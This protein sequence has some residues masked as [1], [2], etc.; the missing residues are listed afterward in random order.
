MRTQAGEVFERMFS[1]MKNSGAGEQ[2]W[3]YP[4][5]RRILFGILGVLILLVIIT[6]FFIA[7]ML[8]KNLLEDSTLHTRELSSAISASIR[9]LMLVRNPDMIQST[10]EGIGKGDSSVVRAFI[11]DKSGRV[12]YSSD[13]KDIG[14]VIDRYAEISCHGCHRKTGA[15]PSDHTTVVEEGGG[16]GLHRHVDA[17][18]NE[19][20]CYGCHART[21]RVIG[22]LIIDRSLRGTSKTIVAIEAVIFGSG[23]L[24]IVVLVPF[25]SRIV[26]R[27]VNKYI[28]EILSQHE[29]LRML[30]IIIERLSKTIDLDELKLIV[31]R[32]IRESFDPDEIDLV[33][34]KH[35]RDPRITVWSR[36][37][38]SVSRKKFEKG[39]A[40]WPLIERWIDGKLLQEEISGDGRQVYM[41][42]SRGGTSHA[43]IIASRRERP[44]DPKGLK[45][46]KIMSSHISVAFENALLYHLAIT[47]ELTALYTNRHF[48]SSIERNFADYARYEERFSLLMIDIDH[49][50][51]VN[52]TYGHMTGDSVL[53]DV[54]RSIL[55]SIRDND[56]AFRYGGEE[57][58]VILPATDAEGAK[59]VAGR[60]REEIGS[61]VFEEGTLNLKVTVSIGV[62]S[63]PA[64]ARTIRD[65]IGLAD[66][67]LYE[68]KR[69]G[70]N[71]V[72]MS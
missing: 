61:R 40:V 12:A 34:H 4:L 59:V 68:A 5:K 60:I 38:D 51:K 13:K 8:R 66:Q 42:I 22:K 30:Y 53:K 31:I 15:P 21:E 57:F 62:A 37:S 70:R 7:A 23:L 69:S 26:S 6:V 72:V 48:R 35:Y 56:L 14:K 18:Y 24:C 52:D 46:L 9:S 32:L 36:E 10:V 17:I 49:F 43:L 2:G 39:D 3:M 29:E 58:A 16:A 54:S 47:D 33:F 63:C 50:K 67:A 27:G 1:D 55:I 11:L 19:Q 64:H 20:E 41:P 25:L 45:I 65:L 28:D 71:R 44:F